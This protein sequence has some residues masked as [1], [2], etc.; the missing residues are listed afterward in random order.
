VLTAR[1]PVSVTRR[2]CQSLSGSRSCARYQLHTGALRGEQQV[3]C[4]T[5]PVV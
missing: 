2:D 4:S 1:E 3:Q 5:G